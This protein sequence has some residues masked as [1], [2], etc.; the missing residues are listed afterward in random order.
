MNRID[1]TGTVYN[2]GA[3]ITGFDFGGRPRVGTVIEY[4][5]PGGWYF[6]RVNSYGDTAMIRV[7]TAAPS[8]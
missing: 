5:A 4:D 7:E 8:C 1:F 2:V 6:V 3:R